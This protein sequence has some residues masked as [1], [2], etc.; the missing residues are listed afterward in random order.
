[1]EMFCYECEQTAKG[2]G[3]TV[4]GVCG[5]IPA[6]SNLQDILIKIMKG[7]SMYACKA[8]E[9]GIVNSAV[10]NYIVDC[11]FSIVTNVNFDDDSFLGL[12]RN[13][14]N[15]RDE[16]K[17]QY[18]KAYLQKH[19]EGPAK[20]E[21][22]ANWIPANTK[23]ELL[24]QWS[25]C[26]VPTSMDK[27]GK[28]ITGLDQLCLHGL[29]GASAYIHHA[30]KLKFSDDTIF[31]RIHEMMSFL[32]TEHTVDDVLKKAL[33]IGEI[34]LSAM[35]ILD[36]AN[37]ETYGHP[38]PT[39]VRV[40]PV[41]GKAILV[42][43][44]DLE[45]LETVLEL[46]E[47]SGINVYTHSEMLP[48]LAY[49]KLK[50]FKHLA[51]NYGGAWHKQQK[52]FAEFPGA[53]LM[54]TNCIQKPRDSYKHRIFTTGLVE[55]P[56]VTHLTHRVDFSKLVES[57][58]NETGFTDTPEEK[59]ITIGFARNAVLSVADKVV[60]MVKDG[61][62]RH[63]FLIGGCDGVKSE[64][65]Y[66]TD[67]A[68]AV[69]D[70]CIILT[71]ACGKYRFNKLDFGDI[72][73]I[74]RLLDIGQ[75]NDAYSGIIIASALAEAFECGINDLPLSFVLSWFEQKAIAILLTL[76]HLGVKNIKIGPSLPASIT[77]EALKV[78]VDIFNIGAITNPEDDLK[79]ILG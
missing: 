2:T 47:S 18:E 78:L 34:N 75:C 16:L 76:L 37:T 77:P 54:T 27:V 40:T 17:A 46:T 38:E 62:I 56:G 9:L 50:K 4:R 63:F 13:S 64:R 29:M 35:E 39:R 66:Y 5:K 69:P 65:S 44:H 49:P 22:P 70:D 12:I 23:D 28:T 57:A 72:D 55:F 53:I 14:V 48:T 32:A 45:D 42:S 1:M 3:C 10:D 68:K 71:L 31:G 61:K 43:G 26:S 36:R 60:K 15:L 25:Q 52:E 20:L 59:A 74:P 58:M 6:V 24:A 7:L 30:N 33:E 8:R 41:K 21:G 19:G 51:G 11:L 67:F 73:G 79:E